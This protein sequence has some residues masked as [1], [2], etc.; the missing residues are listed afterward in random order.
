[1]ELVSR[2]VDRAKEEA[3]GQLNNNSSWEVVFRDETTKERLLAM[4]LKVKGKK[5]AV[6][7]LQK[8]TQRVRMLHVN[9]F[10]TSKLNGLWSRRQR[11]RQRL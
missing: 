8:L 9:E 11:N 4:E 2:V 10:L 3:I 7:K 6:T 5:A 1:M